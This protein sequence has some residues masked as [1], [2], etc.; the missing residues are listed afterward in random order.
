MVRVIAGSDDLYFGSGPQIQIFNSDEEVDK[1][2]CKPK[3]VIELR[4][5]K[6][7]SV[8]IPI[9]QKL[10]GQSGWIFTVVTQNWTRH[11]KVYDFKMVNRKD[12]T[13]WMKQLAPLLNNVRVSIYRYV[14][15]DAYSLIGFLKVPW[16][17]H[18]F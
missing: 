7:F 17:S 13:T 3:E 15:S 4:G 11:P 14:T 16:N 18:V 6:T 9:F 2:G 5:A 1:P 8:N 12:R 10:L